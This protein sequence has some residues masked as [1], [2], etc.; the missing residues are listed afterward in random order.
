MSGTHDSTLADPQ[1]II[2]D[3]R[4]TNWELE[5]RNAQPL[6]E[7]DEALEQQTATAEVLQV[8]NSSP[9]DLTPVFDAM[10]EKA[11]ALCEARYGFLT[12]YDGETYTVAAIRN[13]PKGLDDALRAGP[14]RPGPHTALGRLVVT[15]APVHIEDVRTD[16]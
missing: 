7:R 14:H 9:G 5:M 2:A 1:K 10:L 15:R 3:H 6:A 16:V 4:G 11:M 12:L 13:V 8:I